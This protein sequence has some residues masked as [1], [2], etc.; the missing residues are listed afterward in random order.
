L[1]DELRKGIEFGFIDHNI[2]ASDQF[3]PRLLVNDTT[4]NEKVLT[5]IKS[6]LSTC[7]EFFLSV[8]FITGGGVSA[9]AT[10]LLDAAESGIKGKILAS[11]YQNFTDPKALK[12]LLSLNN[13]EVKIITEESGL[14]MHSKCYIF[15]H[16]QNYNMI[17][18]SSNLTNSALCENKEW[19]LKISSTGEGE[20]VLE[21]IKE[22][23]EMFDKAT[24]VDEAWLVHYEKIYGEYSD[25]SW[26]LS[27]WQLK[28]KRHG[29]Q[30]DSQYVS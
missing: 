27:E 9:I 4:R 10:E 22:F 17:I 5:A 12:T 19:N 26:R 8:A 3:S 24:P 23:N 1:N 18:G 15:R 16:D 13:I 11:Q 6:E 7:D 2:T 25:S 30:N 29:H 20:V 28:R 14:N 21:T